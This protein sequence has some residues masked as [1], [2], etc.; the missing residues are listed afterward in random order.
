MK[1]NKRCMQVVSCV[2]VV[3]LL[4]PFSV[5]AQTGSVSSETFSREQLSQMLAPIALYPDALLAQVLMASTYP[6]EIV[7]ADRWVQANQG[8]KGD[9]LDN[10]LLD[11]PWD[12][13]VKSLCHYP[14]VLTEMSKKLD[15]TSKLGDAFLGQQDE[16]MDTVQELRRRAYDRGNLRSSDQQKVAVDGDSI[17]IEPYYPDVIYVPAYDSGVIYGPWWYPAYPPYSWYYPWY[18][19]GGMISF[20]TGFVVGIF[21]TSWSW[22]DWHAHRVHFAPDKTKRFHRGAGQA[23]SP[24]AQ[25]WSHD[26]SHRRGVAYRNPAT[27]QR[28]GQSPARLGVPRRDVRGFESPVQVNPQGDLNRGRAGSMER[29]N[30]LQPRQTVQPRPAERPSYAPPQQTIQPREAV[31]QRPSPGVIDRPRVPDRASGRD[32]VFTNVNNGSREQ[33]AG[34]RGRESRDRFRQGSGGAG[35]PLGGAPRGGR[36]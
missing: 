3:C 34:E 21:V 20:G 15:R 6:L 33:S 23:L 11:M 32:N 9:A 22:Y 26:P 2:L 29:P 25:I 13:S 1:L 35:A 8:L 12:V 17:L 10:A 27:S 14:A 28:F 4:V 7:E 5:T 16:V 24:N 31:P 19:A 30:V 36:R 18:P